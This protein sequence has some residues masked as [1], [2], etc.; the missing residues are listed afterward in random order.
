MFGDPAESLTVRVAFAFAAPSVTT[1]LEL[2]RTS[3]TELER[4][5]VPEASIVVAPAIEPVFVILPELLLSPPV[6]EAPPDETVSKPPIVWPTVKLLFWPLYATFE[7]VP[8]VLMSVPFN[9]NE[10]TALMLP[11]NDKSPADPLSTSVKSVLGEPLVSLIVNVA[12]ELATP[13]ETTGPISVNASGA[14]DDNVTV[15]E[16]PIVVAADIAPVLLIP[17]LLLLI[18]PVTERPPD[19]MV[20][21]AVNVFD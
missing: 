14:D 6:I 13:N 11:V 15:P 5:T 4:V 18:E 12:F 20:W 10:E 2:E 9:L 19:E 8:V 16:A 17:P 3:G 7:S 1:G 21:A